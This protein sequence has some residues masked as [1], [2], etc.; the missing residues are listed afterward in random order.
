[1]KKP[2]WLNKK[3]DVAVCRDIK[4]LTADL[5]LN[6]VCQEALCPNISECFKNKVAAFMILGNVC[7]RGCRFCAVKK[8]A[9]APADSIEPQ[10]VAQAVAKLGLKHVVITSPTRD[11]LVDGGAYLFA[12][13]IFALKNLGTVE[14][15]EVL[16]PDFLG[17]DYALKTLLAAKPDIVAH[18]METVSDLYDQVRQGADYYR[19]LRLLKRVKEL[20]PST[21]TKSGLMLGVGENKEQ[22]QKLLEDLRAAGC[23]FLS[24][25]QYLPPSTEHHTCQYIEPQDFD[26]WK[27]IA[28]GL[29]FKSVKSSPY[30]RSSYLADSYL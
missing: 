15:V 20:S 5:N 23:E 21:I 16:I 26:N 2:S 8:G 24:I 17:K 7:T 22:V 28:Q 9:P 10:R 29:G 3:V 19:S 1:M 30:V 14:T 4:K 25:G 6:T 12:R 27:L 13:T 18:N 11:D